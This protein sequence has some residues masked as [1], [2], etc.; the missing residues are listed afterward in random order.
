MSVLQDSGYRIGSADFETGLIT[1]M[2]STK[3]KMTWMPFIG[4]GTSKKTPVVSVFIENRGKAMS[5]VRLNFVMGK[6]SNN[7]SFGGVPMRTNLRSGDLSG[8]V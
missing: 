3:T 8:S 4:F 7:G 1:A 2:A 6:I 5:R